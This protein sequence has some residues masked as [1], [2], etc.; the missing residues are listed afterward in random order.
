M[1]LDYFPALADGR[2]FKRELTVDGLIPNAAGYAVMAPLAEAAIAEA[3]KPAAVR[4][5]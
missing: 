5:P 1:Y 4:S 3:L 2:S